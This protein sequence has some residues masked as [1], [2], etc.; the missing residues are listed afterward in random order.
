MV[1]G[2]RVMP[3]L[4]V[5]VTVL[6]AAVARGCLLFANDM[7]PG[8][9]GAYYLVQARSLLEKAALAIPDLP[10]V[11][12]IHAGAAQVFQWLGLAEREAVTLA[13]KLG[14]SLLPALA[15]IPV[16]ALA[17][18]WAER[19]SALN[20]T[21]A[22]LTAL[23][24]PAGGIALGM[25]GDFQ[26][27]SFGIA[28][29]CAL[30]WALWRW[31]GAPDWR[32]GL[33]V[34]AL[35]AAIGLTHIAVFGTAL[36]LCAATLVPHLL[37]SGRAHWRRVMVLAAVAIPVAA[38]CAGVVFWKFDPA[39]VRRLLGAFSDP[40]GFLGAGGMPMGPGADMPM[41][42]LPALVFALLAVPALVM[43]WHGRAALGA[44][45]VAVLGG[46]VITV[47]AITGP[48]VQGDKMHRLQMNAAPLVLLCLLFVLM[49]LPRVWQ[50]ACIGG[51]VLALLLASAVMKWQAG[52]FPIIS[53]ATRAELQF[54][55][56]GVEKPARTLV[57]TRHGLE[58]WTAWEWRTH[59]AQS[60]ALREDDWRK[61]EFVWFLEE[62]RSGREGPPGGMPPFR[63]G[64]PPG[65][66]PPAGTGWSGGLQRFLLALAQPGMSTLGRMPPPGM[67]GRPSGMLPPNGMPPDRLPPRGNDV[68]GLGPRPPFGGGGQPRGGGPMS[69]P[70]P[71]DAAI[72]HE[73]ETLRLGWVRLPPDF[74]RGR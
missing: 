17:A 41:N 6:I 14:D 18:V 55:A 48:W 72:L 74:V 1:A 56:A 73:G 65:L 3:R 68:R 2:C 23:L 64:G 49:R 21:L 27:N 42:W 54:L 46:M 58:W 8:M 50:R 60:K 47:I 31:A 57:V 71:P 62:S 52:A 40:G 34:V 12:L 39:R 22:A 4:I 59:I 9:N 32:R 45:R 7:V 13:V 24:V 37:T 51:P 15:V 70:M 19:R 35:L 5:L 29:L 28:L 10:L 66:R 26:K 69:T 67:N 53:E 33:V 20:T 16:M 25:V 36:V 61:Y 30:V 43:A 63:G 11:F 38:L 44:G